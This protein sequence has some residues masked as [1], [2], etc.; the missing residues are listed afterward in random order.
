LLKGIQLK[1]AVLTNTADNVIKLT[2]IGDIKAPA[3]RVDMFYTDEQIS[4]LTLHH[5]LS[6]I[7]GIGYTTTLNKTFMSGKTSNYS[8]DLKFDKVNIFIGLFGSASSDQISSIGVI[9]MKLD[10][11]SFI[12]PETPANNSSSTQPTGSANNS[13]QPQ[14]NTLPSPTPTEQNNTS[15]SP[16]PAPQNSTSPSPN[17]NNNT[18]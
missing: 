10:C 17:P 15:P 12:P 9:K 11:P 14:N 8:L 7:H 5:N 6:Q 3:C 13:T 1:T 18:S 2:A 4:V 16:T